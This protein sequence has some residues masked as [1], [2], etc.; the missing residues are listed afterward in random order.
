MARVSKAV[1][2]QH[3]EQ[4]LG[5]ASTMLREKGIDGLGVAEAMGAAGLT[6]GG[7][8]GHFPSKDALVAEACGRAFAE[9]AES[10]AQVS[11]QAGGGL[12]ARAA[13]VKRYL[14]G[15]ERLC[16]ALTLATDV[17]RSGPDRPVHEHY[18][19]GVD[20]LV[21]ELAKTFYAPPA[22]ARR[23]AL[24][25]FATLVGAQTLARATGGASL[26]DEVL[27]AVRTALA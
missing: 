23:Q 19:A 12:R 22:E 27:R 15:G 18:A 20:A 2:Q 1:M 24:A 16:P 14:E 5:A 25:L 10:W 11:R 8:Y 13:L 4:I 9:S 7:F 17:A 21:A 3:R 6:H 26:S